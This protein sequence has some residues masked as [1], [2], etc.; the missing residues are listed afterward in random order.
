MAGLIYKWNIFEA[1]GA[2]WQPRY[3]QWATTREKGKLK[4]LLIGV[5]VDAESLK[6]R[7]PVVPSVLHWISEEEDVKCM[8]KHRRNIYDRERRAPK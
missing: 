8:A 5:A 2:H 6:D 1:H 3:I 7:K 4:T